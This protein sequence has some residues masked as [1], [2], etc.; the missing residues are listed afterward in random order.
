MIIFAILAAAA[1]IPVCAPAAAD[2]VWTGLVQIGGGRSIDLYCR[3][4][5]PPTV[6]I[7]PGKGSYADAWNVIVPADDPVRSSP[8]DL[9]AAA[10]LEPSPT[11]TQATVG[12]TQRV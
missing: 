11:A 5:G 1:T 4:A 7:I 2:D 12:P 10:E 9:I 3:G 8:Y 6:L